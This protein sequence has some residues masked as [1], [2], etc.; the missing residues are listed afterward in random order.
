MNLID[1]K[2]GNG[3][4]VKQ[5]MFPHNRIHSA[6]KNIIYVILFMTYAG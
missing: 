5:I 4:L 3:V 1:Q 2:G 6:V